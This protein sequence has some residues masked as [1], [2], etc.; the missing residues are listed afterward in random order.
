MGFSWAARATAGAATVAA[1][2]NT[3][4][5]HDMVKSPFSS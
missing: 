3:T 4:I 2:A 5:F 1:I